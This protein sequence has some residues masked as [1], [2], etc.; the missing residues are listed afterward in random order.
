MQGSDSESAAQPGSG[1]RLAQAVQ[2][3]LAALLVGA[4]LLW[5]LDVPLHIGIPIFTEQLLLSGLGLSLGLIM[6]AT[7]ESSPK[8]AVARRGLYRALAVAGLAACLYLAFSYQRL[9]FTVAFRP[10]DALIAVT[11]MVLIA[12]EGLRRT[13]GWG[14]FIIVLV[15]LFYGYFGH[16]SPGEFR[17]R[18]V[19]LD[20]LALYVG[21]DANGIIGLAL[22]VAMTIVIPFVFFGQL[23]MRC[24]A[25]EFFTNLAAAAMGRYRGGPAKI[26]VVASAL[27]GTISGNAVSNVVS[28]G[29]VT[30]PLMKR[31][32]YP[33]HVAGAVESVAS[34]GGQIMPPVM[35]AAA[36]LM[37]EFLE[38]P[39]RDV[40]VAALLPALLYF[41]AVFIQVDLLAAAM[42]IKGMSREE[43]PS[44]KLTLG[45]GWHFVL[46]F[47][48]LI[49]GLFALKMRPEHAAVVASAILVLFTLLF[50][51]KGKRPTLGELWQSVIAT[52][53]GVTDIIA[54]CAAVG[55]VIGIL[56][57]TGLAFNLTLHLISASGGSLIVLAVLTAAVSIVLGMG[58]P[59]VGVYVLLATLAAPALVKA[60][61]PDIAAHLFVMYFGML[62]MVTPP[63]AIAAFAA[64]NLAEAN[65]WRTSWAAAKLAWSAYIVPFLFIAS[66]TLLFIGPLGE[67]IWAAV[68]ATI[69][70]FA[71]TV[72]IVGYLRDH[73]A[74]WTRIALFV[75]GIAVL[76]PAGAYDGAFY[77][78][79][80]GLA[81]I[82]GLVAMHL[83][84]GR[85]P[86]VSLGRL[87]K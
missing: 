30:I 64:A 45:E 16:L 40:M 50:G 25:A 7:A 38:M 29:V 49:Y 6:L 8:D 80:V 36:F 23:L 46:P 41:L 54:I 17:V 53:K 42:G 19:A 37:A 78:E 68:T 33:G 51:Y 71:A 12:L 34:T 9:A 86:A 83:L 69:G 57:L 22:N 72:G 84:N 60:G 48:A 81:L 56:S 28:T 14:I 43:I 70:I 2:T 11:V 4:S 52:G 18:P 59:T 67:V 1:A 27:F 55:I 75:A 62:S 58:M 35:G 66:P 77:G 76:T 5:T 87:R 24:G 65:P 32:G 20:R 74:L 82:A 31:A 63:V 79:L 85:Q 73:L 47:A 26:S 39:Y 10:L 15:F 61:V 13:S 44:L 21:L 3:I